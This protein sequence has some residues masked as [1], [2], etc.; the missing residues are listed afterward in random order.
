[1]ETTDQMRQ[2]AMLERLGLPAVETWLTTF[3]WL[4][5]AF[6]KTMTCTIKSGIREAEM[7]SCNIF[8]TV[9]Q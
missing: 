8:R 6:P 5:G 4:Y 9:F 2:V 1:M 7:R 3:D